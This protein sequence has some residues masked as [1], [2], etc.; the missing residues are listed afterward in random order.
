M[1]IL[2]KYLSGIVSLLYPKHCAICETYIDEGFFDLCEDCWKSL[3]L[4]GSTQC[5]RCGAYLGPY[6][7]PSESCSRCEEGQFSSIKKVSAI[8]RYKDSAKDLIH[9]LKFDKRRYVAYSLADMLAE[10]LKTEA[11]I[12]KI[13]I[14]VPVP[15]HWRR[16]MVRTFN[17]SEIIASSVSK[18]LKIKYET[19]VIGRKRATKE[20]SR[21]EINERK[22]NLEG[23]F[24][25]SLVNRFKVAGKTILLIDDVMTT[26][27]TLTECAK[28]LKKGNAKAIYGAVICRA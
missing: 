4:I 18:K 24:A 26:G 16:E 25:L 1:N 28:V 27:T 22:K 19:N 12:E 20:Q 9:K 5:Q 3:P 23:A 10:H 17:Q 21:L 2:T 6:T 13:D 11:F 14:I 7:K 15:L 8:F